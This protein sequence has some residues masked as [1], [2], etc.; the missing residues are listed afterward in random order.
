MTLKYSLGAITMLTLE[1]MLEE[2][3]QNLGADHPAVQMLRNQIA[4]EREGQGFQ[5]MYLTGSV[6]SQAPKPVE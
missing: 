3:I 2:Q 4:A 1:Q 6:P 5:E